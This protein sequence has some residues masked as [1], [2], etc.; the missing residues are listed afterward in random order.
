MNGYKVT[1]Y[2]LECYDENHLKYF[3]DRSENTHIVL[4]KMYLI[5][6]I[7]MQNHFTLNPILEITKEHCLEIHSYPNK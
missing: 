1:V 2:E 4:V 5:I 7:M 6:G 3:R